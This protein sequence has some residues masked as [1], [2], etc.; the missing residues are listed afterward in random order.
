MNNLTVE[1]ANGLLA[2]A[3]GRYNPYFLDGGLIAEYLPESPI[4]AGKLGYAT[5]FNN[6]TPA[7]V[8]AESLLRYQQGDAPT[9]AAKSVRD[10]VEYGGSVDY[11]KITPPV[12]DETD[13]DFWKQVRGVA[14]DAANSTVQSIKNSEKYKKAREIYGE[15]YVDTI[16]PNLVGEE[17]ARQILEAAEFGS[18]ADDDWT[19]KLAAR[20]GL[21]TLGVGL[22]IIGVWAAR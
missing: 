13:F 14:A 4:N 21:I 6:S 11:D 17:N 1:S 8:V 16:L 15:E 18:T 5:F 2:T 19:T 10:I 12:F 22:A 3:T 9:R 7:S 20:A